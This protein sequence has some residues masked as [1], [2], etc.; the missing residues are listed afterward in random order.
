VNG[1]YEEMLMNGSPFDAS[2][3]P[4]AYGPKTTEA[5]I[6]AIFNP[7]PTTSPLGSPFTYYVPPESY[8][9]RKRVVVDNGNERVYAEVASVYSMASSSE[10]TTH[11][12]TSGQRSVS[13]SS[14]QMSEDS[15]GEAKKS[16]SWWNKIASR[17]E[18]PGN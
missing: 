10:E 2:R 9:S 11:T 12:T 4:L 15:H 6:E 18:T 5:L 3:L 1:A 16:R 7:V 14:R 17:P 13:G 8:E